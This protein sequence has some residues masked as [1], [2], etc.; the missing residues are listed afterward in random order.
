VVSQQVIEHLDLES[1][2][3]P[4]LGELAR[5]CHPGAELWLSCPDLGKVCAAHAEDGGRW[6]LEDRRTRYELPWEA[7]MPA[8]QM[9]NVLFHQGSEHKN[10]YDFR[11][12]AWLLEQHGFGAVTRVEEAAL[13]ARF[14]EFPPRRDDRVALYVRATRRDGAA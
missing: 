13:R 9:I 3:R 8:S 5:V 14:P 7:D 11:L 4:L 1:E 10:L 2:L 6:L 12:L